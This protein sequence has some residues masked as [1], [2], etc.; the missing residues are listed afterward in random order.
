MSCTEAEKPEKVQAAAG[1]EGAAAAA[2]ASAEQTLDKTDKESEVTNADTTR[3]Q[4]VPQRVVP[5]SYTHLVLKKDK[6][7]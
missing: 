1:A 2:A 5:V 7:Q 6:P 4:D 3:R